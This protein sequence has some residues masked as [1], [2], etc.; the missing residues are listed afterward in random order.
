VTLFVGLDLGTSG[1]RCLVVDDTGARVAAASRPWAYRWL[2]MG[3]CEL[4]PVEAWTA[5]TDATRE[6]LTNVDGA[7]VGAIGVTSQRTGV[8]F[9]DGEGS[10]VSISPNADGRG[11]GPGIELERE[12]GDLVYR[13]AGRLPVMLYLPARLAALKMADPERASKVATTLSL[14]DWAVRKLTGVA[15]TEPTQAAEMLVFDLAAGEWS[16]EL[17]RCLEVPSALLPAILPPGQPAGTVTRQAAEAFGLRSDLRTVAA[18]SDT[19][20]AALAMGVTQP[21]QGVVVAG[22]TMLCE[23]PIA[24][25]TIDDA[26]RLWTSPHLSGGFVAE[27]HCGESGIPIQWMADLMGETPEWIDQAAAD[28]EPGAGGLFFLDAA[29]S[30]VGDFPMMRA[31]SLSFPAPLLALA[32]SRAD[33]ARAVLEGVAFAAKA[34]LEWTQ[35]VAGPA[36]DLAVTGGVSRSRAFATILASALNH[37]VRAATEPLGSALGAAIVAAVATYQSVRAAADAMADRGETIE[38]EPS[39]IGPTAGAYSGWRERVRHMDDNTMRVGH[40]IGRA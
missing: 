18:G 13:T 8:V 14:S 20:A 37:P 22:S 33:V 30:T 1:A 15:A 32:R 17:L 16:D 36:E 9:L 24:E 23:Q 40:M 31:G 7:D 4:D 5:V 10:E 26:K 34:G 6:A 38:P 25:P 19:Q 28:S 3:A 35:E 11:V 39:W 21:G 12:H 29:P 27:A 2:G